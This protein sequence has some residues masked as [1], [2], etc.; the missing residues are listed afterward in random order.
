MR[1]LDA[2]SNAVCGVLDAAELCRCAHASKE[3]RDA[4]DR[5]FAAVSGT[6]SELNADA[7]L[8][9]ALVGD[10]VPEYASGPIYW[11]SGMCSGVFAVGLHSVRGANG[12][13]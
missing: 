4:A 12:V 10:M 7:R 13:W 6:V 1:R 2:V 8:Y 9:A 11:C 5:A 3:W